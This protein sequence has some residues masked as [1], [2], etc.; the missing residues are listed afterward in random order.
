MI[1]D[2]HTEDITKYRE[3]LDRDKVGGGWEILEQ[4]LRKRIWQ[5]ERDMADQLDRIEVL[6]IILCDKFYFVVQKLIRLHDDLRSEKE[7]LLALLES[8]E[9]LSQA[10]AVDME[11]RQ[12]SD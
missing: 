4:Q 11:R 5:Q 7:E 6:I 9:Q 3:H 8:K 1:I 10:T 12:V 2:Q